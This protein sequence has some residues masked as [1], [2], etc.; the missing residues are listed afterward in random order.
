MRINTMQDTCTPTLPR[1]HT[2]THTHKHTNTHTTHWNTLTRRGV[3]FEG[4][5][6]Q[7]EHL[8]SFVEQQ[9]ES[10]V[11]DALFGKLGRR[12]QFDAFHLSKM[13]RVTQHVNIQEFG[14]VAVTGS[15]IRSCDGGA[16]NGDDT[17]GRERTKEEKKRARQ[18][19]AKQ[20]Q[21]HT[22]TQP[23][24]IPNTT[25]KPCSLKAVRIKAPSLAIVALSSAAV[26]HARTARI[27]SLNFI[28][29][30]AYFH[31]QHKPQQRKDDTCTWSKGGTDSMYIGSWSKN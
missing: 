29:I 6:D 16:C 3:L 7:H 26:L 8:L 2:H 19:P 21:T 13:R 20:S 1:T 10:Q 17:V 11:T 5:G 22:T 12:N 30:C 15:T 4:I 28:D 31:R 27:N 18:N 14:H 24:T 9:H 23:N 25:H